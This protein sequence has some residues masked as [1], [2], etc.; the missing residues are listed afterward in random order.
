MIGFWKDHPTVV[1]AQ[2]ADASFFRGVVW[3]RLSP[4]EQALSQGGTN[5]WSSFHLLPCIS[6]VSVRCPGFPGSSLAAPQ[7]PT[8]FVRCKLPVWPSIR[9]SWPSP[10]FGLGFWVTEGSLW[11]VPVRIWREVGARVSLNVKVQDLDLSAL[12]SQ[13]NRQ[14]RLLLTGCHCS[15]GRIWQWTPPWC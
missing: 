3:P 8:H 4:L 10:S 9:V 2:E 14:S 15:T 13:D 1:V 11:K 5:G 12:G 6:P 7:V